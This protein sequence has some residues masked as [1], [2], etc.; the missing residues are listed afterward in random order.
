MTGS[1][2]RFAME[3]GIPE[4][5]E[6]YIEADWKRLRNQVEFEVEEEDMNAWDELCR[7]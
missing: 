7:L 6:E 3:F 5:W 4:D 2:E 1:I